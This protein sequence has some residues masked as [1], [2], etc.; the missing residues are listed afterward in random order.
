MLQLLFVFVHANASLFAVAL[1]A[2]AV[3]EPFFAIRDGEDRVI[4]FLVMC[5]AGGALIIR[6]E[7]GALLDARRLRRSRPRTSLTRTSP[8]ARRS[9]R[10][11]KRR[12]CGSPRAGARRPSSTPSRSKVAAR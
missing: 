12:S 9:G 3:V 8:T 11:T 7:I 10:S 2:L 4:P 5:G 1:I 6:V